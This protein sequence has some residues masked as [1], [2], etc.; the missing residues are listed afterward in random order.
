[1][2]KP[3]PKPKPSPILRLCTK[4]HACPIPPPMYVGI[5]SHP[6]ALYQAQATFA[7]NALEC[8]NQMQHRR[9][10]VLPPNRS[11]AIM[12]N[13]IRNQNSKPFRNTRLK[14]YPPIT[15]MLTLKLNR[16]PLPKANPK[17]NG[18]YGTHGR[19]EFITG[20]CVPLPKA[21]PKPN[22]RLPDAFAKWRAEAAHTPDSNTT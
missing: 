19:G 9:L 14:P 7:Q 3:K 20:I 16:V 8:I 18:P 12:L 6:Q 13:P 17:P 2:G 5:T 21:N 10:P 4:P 1:M 22:P 11:L 15:V